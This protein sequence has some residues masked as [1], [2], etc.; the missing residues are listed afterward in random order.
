M[1]GHNEL[2]R[3]SGERTPSRPDGSAAEMIAGRDLTGE[4]VIVTGGP[5]EWDTRWL[6]SASAPVSPAP[7]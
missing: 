6:R 3:T 7:A 2:P 1:N 4:E 5:G